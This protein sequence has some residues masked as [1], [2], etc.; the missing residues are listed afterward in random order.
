M[1]ADF[2]PIETVQIG[3]TNL[4]RKFLTDIAAELAILEKG[5]MD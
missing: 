3:K 5:R 2:D 4:Q 1:E